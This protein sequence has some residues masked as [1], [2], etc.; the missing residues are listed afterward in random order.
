MFSQKNEKFNTVGD[1]KRLLDGFSDDIPVILCGDDY[2]WFCSE[3]D[4]SVVY[5]DVEE[6]TNLE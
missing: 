3:E 4:G 5:L 2:C 6:L 1:L